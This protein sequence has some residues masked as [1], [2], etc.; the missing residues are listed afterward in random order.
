MPM[1]KHHHNDSEDLY[2][3]ILQLLRKLTYEL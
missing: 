2:I 3:G 1:K